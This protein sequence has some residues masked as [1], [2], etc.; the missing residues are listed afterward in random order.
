MLKLLIARQGTCDSA[1]NRS[2]PEDK[3]Q[4]RGCEVM[5]LQHEAF[6][7]NLSLL[8]VTFAV[9]SAL[10]MLIRQTMGGKLSSFD[11]YLIT[12]YISF[13]FAQVIIGVLPGLIAIYGLSERLTWTISGLL[14]AIVLGSVLAAVVA[15]RR[16]ASA[17]PISI[18][19]KAAFAVHALAACLFL[20]VAVTP[21]WLGA[22]LY[23]TGLTLSLAAVMWSFVRRI[24][25][26]FGEH[27][28]DDWDPSRG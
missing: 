5:E 9:I 22:G 12:A 28:G 4:R 1:C 13:G 25:S 14:A 20:I 8:A 2:R 21:A 3:F 6:F 27:V 10:V 19:V 23:A 17:A 18:S 7:L 24:A 26:L 11:V 15:Q 16:K